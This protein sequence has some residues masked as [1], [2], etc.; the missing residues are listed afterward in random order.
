MSAIGAARNTVPQVLE[1]RAAESPTSTAFWQQSGAQGWQPITWHEFFLRVTN[2]R[3]ALHA[4]GLR[5]GDRLALIAPVSL[6]WELLHHAALA[7]GVVVVGMDAH[8]LPARIAAQVEQ[9][10]IAAFATTDPA[11]LSSVGAERLRD[12]RFVLDIVGGNQLSSLANGL[13]WSELNRLGESVKTAPPS[14]EADDCATIIFTSG[15]TGA[16]KGIAY[17]HGQICLA[18]E[19]I[20]SVF[21]FVDQG[22]RLLCWLPLSN[23]FQRMVN[24][25]GMRNG[26]ATHLLS[27]PRQVM[28]VVATT[29]PDV[30]I[31]V[32][33]FYEKLYQG[34]CEKID[35]QPRLRRKL[36]KAAWA[37]GRRVSQAR[38]ENRRTSPWLA[39]AHLAADRMV[40]RRIRRV[41]GEGLRCMVSGSAPIQKHL[42][43]EFHALGWLV[44]EAYGLSENVLPMAMNR[45]DDFHFGTV[46]RPLPGNQIMI[47]GDGTIKVRG[48]GTFHGYLDEPGPG[49]FDA[50][51]F[52]STGD[53]GD[54]DG[55][56]Y[57]RLTGR[58]SELI[59]TSSGRRIAPAAVEAE[60]RSV[61]GVDQ[62]V[63][64]GAGRKCLVALCSTSV[65]H[66]AASTREV[67]EASL[68]KQVSLINQHE[69]P[70][71]IGLIEHPF[72]IERGDL[73]PNLKLKRAAIE[74]RYADLI[75]QLYAALDEP[76]DPGRSPIVV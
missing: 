61:P 65:D 2:L 75:G 67:L 37:I 24:L 60:L 6:D 63:L 17:S 1:L 47:G 69:R 64:I 7:M 8:D 18:I 70:Q 34:V 66:L 21:D 46:G 26:A 50:E 36:I 55:N 32:P 19:A 16:P 41:M 71:A 62:A 4:T 73:T 53:Y 45:P 44:L 51:G 72:S 42:L 38:L 3:N 31:G 25:A 40:L 15:T 58:T 57:L 76:L 56:G 43:E 39:W 9:A 35:A 27:D 33:R 5:K 52:Y 20:G 22:S 54:F 28:V 29:S 11:V 48:P 23:L 10:D 14:P 74:E 13:T 59:K 49:L 12:C 30:F 68:V